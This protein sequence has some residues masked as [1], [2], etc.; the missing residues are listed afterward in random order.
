MTPHTSPAAPDDPGRRRCL[1]L[2]PVLLA[3]PPLLRAEPAAARV[4]GAPGPLRDLLEGVAADGSNTHGVVVRKGGRLLAEAYYTGVD[5]PGGSWFSREVAFGP[6]TLH[7]LRSISKSVVALLVGVA[8]TRGLLGDPARP[9]FDHFPEHVDLLTPQRRMLTVQHLLDMATGWRWDETSYSYA[10]PRNSELRMSLSPDPLRYMLELPFVAN[11]G[12]TWEY[13]GGATLVLAEILE[14]EAGAPLAKLA[15]DWLFEP[16]GV[17]A[18]EWRT[19]LSGKALPFSGLRLAPRDLATVGELL[20]TRGQH[21]GKTVVPTEWIASI[22]RPRY[23]GWDRYRYASQ[24][25][26]SREEAAPAWVGGWGNGGQRLLVVP[27][28]DLVV[29]V[30]AGRYNQPMSGRASMELF[31]RILD[32]LA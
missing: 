11:P 24:W 9:A 7:D 8:R 13:C 4:S 21:D 6:D 17:C 30:T 18:F 29:V 22:R 12:I 1:A 10:D 15:R 5:K 2:A 31:R 32:V 27:E 16:L 23:T 14:R 20:V 28:R 3:V 19:G 26:H 25:W